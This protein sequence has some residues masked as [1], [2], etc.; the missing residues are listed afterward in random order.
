MIR[1]LFAALNPKDFTVAVVLPSL[2]WIINTSENI[3]VASA[4]TGGSALNSNNSTAS[5]IT[6]HVISSLQEVSQMRSAQNSLQRWLQDVPTSIFLSGYSFHFFVF[7][8]IVALYHL[9]IIV[10]SANGG[11]CWLQQLASKMQIPLVVPNLNFAKESKSSKPFVDLTRV[12][13]VSIH[14]ENLTVAL[15]LDFDKK[16]KDLIEGPLPPV[17]VDVALVQSPIILA[18]ASLEKGLQIGNVRLFFVFIQIL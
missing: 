2:S 7:C 13:I 8:R 5:E 15:N 14:A 18:T 6:L 9:F 4:T 17:A 1:L 12:D 3:S 10:L 16:F 11:T